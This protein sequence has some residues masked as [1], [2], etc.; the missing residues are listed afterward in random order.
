MFED[1]ASGRFPRT[2]TFDPNTLQ[3][4]VIPNFIAVDDEFVEKYKTS[5]RI[6][7]YDM[8]NI[9][10]PNS[11]KGSLP[12]DNI[13]EHFSKYPFNETFY[14]TPDAIGVM[15]SLPGRN[16]CWVE[17]PIVDRWVHL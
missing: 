17:V 8:Q 9:E 6:Y 12:E 2:L 11:V 10:D 1:A 4:F 13:A 16:Y 5:E 14:I 3:S 7:I 15:L